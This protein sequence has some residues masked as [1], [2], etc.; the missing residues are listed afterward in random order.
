MD[1]LYKWLIDI[2]SICSP[3][4]VLFIFIAYIKL[5]TSKKYLSTR[6]NN[7]VFVQNKKLA[8]ALA[9]LCFVTTLLGLCTKIYNEDPFI[10]TMNCLLPLILLSMSV[11]I[12]IISSIYNKKENI[13]I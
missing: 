5:K 3:I 13:K 10:F 2:N 11:I 9:S 6:E 12:P 4:Y 1:S 7:F 8:I